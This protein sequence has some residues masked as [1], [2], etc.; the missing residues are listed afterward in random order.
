[1]AFEPEPSSSVATAIAAGIT[2]TILTHAQVLQQKFGAGVGSS[3]DIP[4]KDGINILER[5]GTGD[6]MRKLLRGIA[7]NRSSDIHH[8]FIDPIQFWRNAERQT[9][10]EKEMHWSIFMSMN[11]Y[12][13]Q[14]S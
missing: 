9:Q 4:V 12:L 14:S 13:G 8:L 3:K 10:S 2:A 5:M 11:H 1:M 6:G 7:R